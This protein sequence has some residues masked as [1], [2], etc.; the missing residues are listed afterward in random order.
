MITSTF[1]DTTPGNGVKETEWGKSARSRGHIYGVAGE[2]GLELTAHPSTP[3]TVNI[4]PAPDGFWGHGVWD[5]SDAVTTI[6]VTPPAQGVTRWDLIAAHRDWQPTG[7]GPTALIALEGLDSTTF[8]AGKDSDPGVIDDQPVWLVK[9]V[10]GQTQPQAKIDLRCW[11]A[12]AGAYFAMNGEVLQY[13]EH[14]GA[15]VYL[16]GHLWRYQP[17][18]NGVW[19]FR[20][21][22]FETSPWLPPEVFGNGFREYGSPTQTISGWNGVRYR[23]VNGTG[24]LNGASLKDKNGNSVPEGTSICR[25][26]LIHAPS[27]RVRGENCFLEPDGNVKTAG[28]VAD[29]AAVSFAVSWALEPDEV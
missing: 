2:S 11:A 17:V 18:R 19:G 20:S 16:G 15:E 8:M 12:G 27:R 28:P 1:Y 6:T 5:V 29:G 4:G 7:G 21:T 3:Y 13:L 22:R 9:W 23:V 25:I 24:H 14:P 10:G 26:P